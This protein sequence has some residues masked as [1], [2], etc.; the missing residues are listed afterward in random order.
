MKSMLGII[1][2]DDFTMGGIPDSNDRSDQCV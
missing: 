1:Q 2:A